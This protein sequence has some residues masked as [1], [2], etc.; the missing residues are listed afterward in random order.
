[1]NM[2]RFNHKI[3][4]EIA[5]EFHA[6]VIS[7]ILDVRVDRRRSILIAILEYIKTVLDTAGSDNYT[8]VHL[9]FREILDLILLYEDGD[10]LALH[11]IL[12][13]ILASRLNV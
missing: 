11:T 12:S 1:M 13:D 3:L 5:G 10:V 8:P 6:Q 9:K 4:T 2:E 7:A